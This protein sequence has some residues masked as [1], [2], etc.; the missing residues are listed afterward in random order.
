MT[1]VLEPERQLCQYI[2]TA[3]PAVIMIQGYTPHMSPVG[4]RQHTVHRKLLR[5]TFHK[6]GY[7][8]FN[9]DSHEYEDIHGTAAILVRQELSSFLTCQPSSVAVCVSAT[10]PVH[11]MHGQGSDCKQVAFVATQSP[12]ADRS[13]TV[14]QRRAIDHVVSGIRAKF[15]QSYL[16]IGGSWGMR[17]SQVKQ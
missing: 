7:I 12:E 9:G 11:D 1:G 2:Q 15:K 14:S 17:R 6:L 10:L 16:V 13:L 5:N 4:A 8:L 3:H